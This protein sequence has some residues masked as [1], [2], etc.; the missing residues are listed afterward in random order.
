MAAIILKTA[1]RELLRCCITFGPTS[2]LWDRFVLE[3]EKDIQH[4]IHSPCYM[5][6]CFHVWN[7][8]VFIFHTATWKFPLPICLKNNHFSIAALVQISSHGRRGLSQGRKPRLFFCGK[9]H[10]MFWMKSFR[11]D[12]HRGAGVLGSGSWLRQR[13]AWSSGII[14]SGKSFEIHTTLMISWGFNAKKTQQLHWCEKLRESIEKKETLLAQPIPQFFTVGWVRHD[15]T[16]TPFHD[17]F[18]RLKKF[19]P[20]RGS[21][22]SLQAGQVISK[23][24]IPSDS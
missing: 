23:P 9:N 20:L 1:D 5:I 6:S 13:S 22:T 24:P 14:G 21:A 19:Q 16:S 8:R 12:E 2:K 4:T 11:W 15:W 18:T 7:L 10:G 17:T 3:P